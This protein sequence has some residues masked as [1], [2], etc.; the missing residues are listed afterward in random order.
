MN[1]VTVSFKV[2]GKEYSPTIPFNVTLLDCLRD[3]LGITSPKECCGMGEC[4]SCTVIMNGKTVNSCLILAVEAA[5]TEITTVEGLS[6]DGNLTPL[7]EAFIEAGAVQCGFCTPGMIMSAQYLLKQN[8]HPSEQEIK[9]GLSGNLCRCTG[10]VRIVDAVL[11][12]SKT[13][14]D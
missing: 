7:Q 1:R 10:Y 3:V 11:K 9:E 12:V 8:P 5:G 13:S 4:G 6:S 2:N 14:S